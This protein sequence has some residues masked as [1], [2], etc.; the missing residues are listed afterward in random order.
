MKTDL[1]TLGVSAT[2]VRALSQKLQGLHALCLA[3]A[4]LAPLSDAWAGEMRCQSQKLTDPPRE[5]LVCSDGTRIT[6]EAETVYS[7]TDRNRDGLPDGAVL[8]GRGL[9]IEYAPK[10][11]G[12][13]QILTP[14]AVTSVR[15]T[16]WAVDVTEAGT[17]V[18]VEAG[19]VAVSKAT[20]GSGVTL[21]AGEGVDV[22]PGPE[23]L[24][25]KTW[26]AARRQN[27]LARF[28]R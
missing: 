14:H 21:G 28:G 4:A 17:A 11:R 7:L 22:A 23:P 16:T 3:L 26:G 8:Q 27:L 13:F 19:R 15:G 18:F 24:A 9:L 5:T 1:G 20:G 10:R 6:A 2:R 25:V 12:G